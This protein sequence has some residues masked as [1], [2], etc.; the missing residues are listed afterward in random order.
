MAKKEQK[1]SKKITHVRKDRDGVITYIKGSIGGIPFT[2]LTIEAV[3][4]INYGRSSYYVEVVPPKV[5]VHVY[6]ERYLRSTPD[7]SSSNNL[8]NL[9][10]F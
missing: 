9:P 10:T 7:S 4:N 2:E 8:D 6:K 3:N 5:D 1:M